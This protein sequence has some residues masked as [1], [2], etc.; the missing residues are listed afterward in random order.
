[1][2]ILT[3]PSLSNGK[4]HEYS[5]GCGGFTQCNFKNMGSVGYPL[6]ETS[7]FLAYMLKNRTV[8]FSISYFWQCFQT[9]E[10]AD[11]CCGQVRNIPSEQIQK[12]MF[13]KGRYFSDEESPFYKSGSFKGRIP[14]GN[15]MTSEDGV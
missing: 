5:K 2:N 11:K 1:M 7:L 4:L 14:Q 8:L 10:L 3:F 13:E 15:M 12:H 9:S 6:R